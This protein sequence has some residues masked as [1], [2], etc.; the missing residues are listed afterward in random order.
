MNQVARP[1]VFTSFDFEHDE[2]LR[3]LFVGQ[4]RNSNTPFEI[5][6]WSLKEALSGNW[7]EKVRTRIR[8]VDKVIVLCGEHTD[9]ANGVSIE[10]RIAQDEGKPVYFIR[11]RSNKTCKLPVAAL[12]SDS[13][14][15]WT[16]ENL[17]VLLEGRGFT[18]A[19]VEPLGSKMPWLFALGGLAFLAWA[20]SR[21]VDKQM[22]QPQRFP[23]WLPRDPR[24]FRPQ[25][26]G[27]GRDN[28][29][30]SRRR[31]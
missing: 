8:R 16:W 19:S 12:P 27:D 25:L 31:W 15:P 28:R 23:E 24:T 10:V 29:I 17:K 21:N 7:K 3:T 18:E 20:I 14:K 5:V 4:S 30:E 26:W 2:D 1:R 6:D 13:M 9:S 11:G 22:V